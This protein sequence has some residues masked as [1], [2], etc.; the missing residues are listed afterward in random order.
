LIAYLYLTRPPCSALPDH[1]TQVESITVVDGKATQVK[2]STSCSQPQ[3]QQQQCS[4]AADAVVLAAGTR[5][6]QL[7]GQAG[8]QLPLLEKPAAVVMTA[9][10]QLGLL[11]HM[12]ISDTVFM[13]QVRILSESGS[14][15]EV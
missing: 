8:C 15:L 14:L 13:L 5:C 1:A 4:Y 9:P 6:P 3:Q 12:V 10:M 2:C 7:A 11:K